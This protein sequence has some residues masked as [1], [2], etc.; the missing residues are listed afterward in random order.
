MRPGLAEI[1]ASKNEVVPLRV[2]RDILK[3]AAAFSRAGD[4]SGGQVKVNEVL[5]SLK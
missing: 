5:L 3:R 1:A 4:V 2:E